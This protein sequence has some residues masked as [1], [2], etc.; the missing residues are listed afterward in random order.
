MT[1]TN[2]PRSATEATI[3]AVASTVG[4]GI[5][6][7]TYYADEDE[8]RYL[9]EMLVK[10]KAEYDKVAAPYIKRLMLIYSLRPAPPVIVTLTP[11]QDEALR[12]LMSNV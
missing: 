3:G 8:E 5:K 1:E 12:L 10:I 7:D 11:E 6:R 2:A 9:K 4:L